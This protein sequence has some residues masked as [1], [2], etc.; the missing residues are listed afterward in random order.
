MALDATILTTFSSESRL[1]REP[2][3]PALLSNIANEDT[4]MKNFTAVEAAKLYISIS[5]QR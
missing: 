2:N 1:N 5:S 4:R 3:S